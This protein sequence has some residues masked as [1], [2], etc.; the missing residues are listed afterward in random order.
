MIQN[1]TVTKSDVCQ[2]MEAFF[3]PVCLLHI[4]PLPACL[5]LLMAVHILL[6]F[7]DSCKASA[8][9]AL[10]QF[11]I[12]M[13]AYYVC[14]YATIENQDGRY[15]NYKQAEQSRLQRKV[16]QKARFVMHTIYQ[17]PQQAEVIPSWSS[18]FSSFKSCVL[19]PAW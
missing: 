1:T 8:C 13:H 14:I 15:C 12:H 19:K 5:L 2:G 4:H 11:D 18:S 17:Q 16:L 7:P 10:I 6:L 3:L 9:M